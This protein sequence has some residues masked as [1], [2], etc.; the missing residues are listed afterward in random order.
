[1]STTD[2]LIINRL[3]AGVAERGASDLH[4]TVGNYPYIRING[5]LLILA[6]ETLINPE[7][8]EAFISFFLP[9]DKLAI[10]KA[11][12]ELKFIYN[13]A[14]K[15]RLRLHLFQQKGYFSLSIKLINER[16]RTLAELGLPKIVSSF[17]QTLKGLVIVSGPVNSGRSATVAALVE[18][19]NQTRKERILYLEEPIEQLF[20]NQQSVIEQREV[21]SDVA[22]FAQGLIFAKEEDINVIAV[23]RV[24]GLESLELILELAESGRLVIVAMDYD[25]AISCLEGLVSDFPKSKQD[26]AR[27]VLAEYLVG[28]IIQRLLPGV[29]GGLV[30]AVEILTASS[31]AKSLIKDGRFANLESIIQTSRAEGMISLDYSLAALVKNGQ[32]AEE[33]A[34]TQATNPK[35]LSAI[36]KK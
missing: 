14:G 5:G 26:W 16:L 24:D 18:A 8:M 7:L 12:K 9:E 15:G 3:L 6:E 31:S 1:M 11:K 19:I 35:T 29:K 2:N 33:V 4:L 17:A 20:V 27:S 23:S 28:V 30:L 36:I 10:L 25:T 22:T 13:W 21:E 32:V 34:L